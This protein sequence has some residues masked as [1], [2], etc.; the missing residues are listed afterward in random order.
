L[1]PILVGQGFIV[2][3]RVKQAIDRLAHERLLDETPQGTAPAMLSLTEQGRLVARYLVD[4]LAEHAEVLAGGAP[5]PRRGP[6]WDELAS[7]ARHRDR[8]DLASGPREAT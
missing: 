1:D 6:L 8:A 2:G 5:H 4:R 3:P 7:Q